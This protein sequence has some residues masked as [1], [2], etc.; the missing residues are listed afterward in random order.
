M[1]TDQAL[2]DAARIMDKDALVKIF[3][4]Y[5][6]AL[7]KYAVHLSGDPI[8]ADHIVGDVFVRLLDQLALGKGPVSNLRSYLYETA[9]HRMID[10]TRYRRRKAPIE[11][12]EALSRDT[13]AALLCL[14][15]QILLKRALDAVQ[16]ELTS[17]QRCVILLRFIEGYSI[18]ETAGALGKTVNHI[19]VLQN[20]AIAELRKALVNG[21]SR[22]ARLSTK[23]RKISRAFSIG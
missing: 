11:G 2:L 22:Q 4:L 14:E 12:A 5:S 17:D 23:I 16:N 21:T 9:Y 6:P 18:R 10:E 3:D 8:L 15:D 7:F 1:E 19:K 20:R 13:H